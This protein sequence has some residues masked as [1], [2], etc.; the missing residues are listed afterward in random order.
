MRNRT[1]VGDEIV[2]AE[3]RAAFGEQDF[4]RAGAPGFLHHL[5]HFRRRQELALFE[6]DDLAGDGGGFNQ[7][8]LAAEEGGDLQDVHDFARDGGMGFVMDVGQNRHADFCADFGEH[9][10]ALVKPG[11]A[12]GI[13]GGAVGLVEAG[14]EDVENAELGAG[15]FQGG[16]HPQAKLFIFNHAR[17]GDQKQPARR[18]EIFPDGSVVEH[19]EVLAAKRRKVNG[20]D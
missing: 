5:A 12:E 1:Q 3:S 6:I 18:I 10:Q 2:V 11:T 9:A 20:G 4:F 13:G 15:F 17:S 16:G 19:T 14:L 8:R 7:I